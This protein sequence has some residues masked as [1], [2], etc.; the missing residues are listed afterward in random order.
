MGGQVFTPRPI[1]KTVLRE[2][3]AE[4][5][6]GCTILWVQRLLEEM[7]LQIEHQVNDA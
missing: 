4:Y 2:I 7:W 1:Y 3:G 5:R 6:Y